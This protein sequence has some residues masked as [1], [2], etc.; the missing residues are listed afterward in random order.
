[1]TTTTPKSLYAGT[2]SA[3]VGT[4]LYTVPSSTTTVITSISV[5]NKTTAATTVT[6]AAAGISWLSGA[7]I[8]P[9]ETWL[10]GP[11]DVRDVLAAA[12]TITGGAGAA[13]SV[14]VR[15][16]GAEIT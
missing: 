2:L 6:L 12:A 9:G 13:S 14:D 1:M 16:A 7:T 4:T 10:I 3:S 5:C 15:I 11:D 8:N